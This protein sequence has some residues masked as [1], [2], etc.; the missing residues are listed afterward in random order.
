MSDRHDWPEYYHGDGTPKRP[1]PE[2]DRPEWSREECKR[3]GLELAREFVTDRAFA[4]EYLGRVK[5]YYA[6]PTLDLTQNY[7]EIIVGKIWAKQG[8]PF[9]AHDFAN[10]HRAAWLHLLE[11][12]AC[13]VNYNPHGR[14]NWGDP[15][16]NDISH[17]EPE[18]PGPVGVDLFHNVPNKQG[19]FS[20]N[21]TDIPPPDVNRP[22]VAAPAG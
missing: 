4:N 17:G 9:N 12:F 5:Q 21:T 3:Y 6:D 20:M 7:R 11:G 2:P 22:V 18:P 15:R 19:Y 13:L 16:P 1:A 10:L 14:G 8:Q